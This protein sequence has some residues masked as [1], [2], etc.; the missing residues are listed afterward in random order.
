MLLRK[1][2]I[3]MVLFVIFGG[4]YSKIAPDYIVPCPGL[5]P[6]CL[7]KNIQETLPHFVKGIPSLGIESLDPLYEE[8][9]ELELPGGLKIEFTQGVITGLRKCIVES[10]KYD[11]LEA[12]LVF[13]CNIL[14]KG[15][16]KANGRVLIFQINGDGDAKIRSHNI[17]L[18][19]KV[20]FEDRTHDGVIY[21][22]IKEY[23]VSYKHNDRVTFDMTNLFK[24]NPELG[25]TVLA[26]LNENWDKV[27]EEFGKPVIDRVVQSTLNIIK[28]FFRAIPRD[29]LYS[30]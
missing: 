18:K 21:R 4:S 11:G 10:A 30:P 3:L 19:A 22:E 6:D 20:K 23:K 16:Y 5:K 17:T 27:I 7:K 25:Q 28:K 2:M 8:R 12:T 1:N 13:N 26:F 15:K 14:L 29:E 24:G 9:V